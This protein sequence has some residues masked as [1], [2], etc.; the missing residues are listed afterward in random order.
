LLDDA[1]A[2]F[3]DGISIERSFDEPFMALLRAEGFTDI[4]LIHG[5]FEM[6]KDVIARREGEQWVFQT[7]AG[8]V[9]LASFRDIRNQLY[10]A[11]MSDIAA[12]GF[13]KHATRV[14]VLVTTGRLVGGANAAAQ[15]YADKAVERGEPH[16]FFWQ[17]D[18]LVGKF[19]GNADAALRTSV[20][21]QLHSV[22]GAIGDE[23]VDM[24][25]IEA[26]SRRWLSWEPSRIVG[27]G[28]IETALVCERLR[29]GGRLDLAAHLALCATRAGW[30]SPPET[31]A[32]AHA[33]GALF[34]TYA[35]LLWAECDD[36]L[37]QERGIVGYSGFSAW[38]T[39]QIR[40][41]RLAEI[42]ALLA[43]RV[44]DDNPAL[45]KSIAEWL[46]RFAQAQPGLARALG[47]RYAVS[48]I[49]V[50]MLLNRDHRETVESLLRS[51]ANWVCNRYERG[52]LGL[53]D[54]E[55]SPGEEL[56]RILGA[57][58]Q[59]VALQRR[60]TSQLAAVLLDLA[61]LLGLPAVYSDI[62]ND[63]LAVG[64][65]P[66]VL[67]PGAGPDWLSRTGLANRWDFNVVYAD[68]L[69]GDGPAAPH[70]S[71]DTGPSPLPAESWW[72]GLAVSAAL[73]D[74]HFPAVLRQCIA[75]NDSQEARGR[76][77]DVE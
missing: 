39:Y 74:R 26:F 57:P 11:R 13:D 75:S 45:A 73:R 51:T 2:A 1:V 49:P 27:V 17:K 41:V 30:V 7:K 62:R 32:A 38:V 33:A 14:A 28:I 64:L 71:D 35:S 37:L 67:L 40:C 56:S 31:S 34:E 23:S 9:N 36:R 15:E 42:V 69:Q 24:D 12:P 60:A 20:D 59:H 3:L 10:D 21:G 58:F 61:A 50:A 46:A 44:R 47:D 55:A 68:E 19:S 4:H 52:N 72:D 54:V 48:L 77:G 29:A 66:S 63:T 43:L 22:L 18:T 25:A 76:L 5:L 65:Y 6:G 16:V 8:D 70:L 53:G